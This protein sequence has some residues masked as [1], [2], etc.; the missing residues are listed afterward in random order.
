MVK[1][2]ENEFLENIKD[3]FQQ[4]KKLEAQAT[5]TEEDQTFSYGKLL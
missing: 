2:I 1:R 4:P 5:I 3:I